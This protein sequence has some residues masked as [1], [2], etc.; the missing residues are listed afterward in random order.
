[1]K[2]G[3]RTEISRKIIRRGIAAVLCIAFTAG[4][5]FAAPMN[6]AAAPNRVF[7]LAQARRLALSNSSDYKKKV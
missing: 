7:L 2:G 5:L 4:Q 6:A 1:M 3:R